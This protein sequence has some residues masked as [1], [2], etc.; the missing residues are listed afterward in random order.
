VKPR[1][2]RSD[3]WPAERLRNRRAAGERQGGAD[4]SLTLRAK[5]KHKRQRGS[6]TIALVPL[7]PRRWGIGCAV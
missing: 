6:Q 5:R 4:R 1:V 7:H 3:G 2:L